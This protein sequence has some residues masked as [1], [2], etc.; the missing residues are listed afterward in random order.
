LEEEAVR[1]I[2][3]LPDFTPGKDDGKAVKVPYKLPIAFEINE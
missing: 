3:L 1:V 2:S